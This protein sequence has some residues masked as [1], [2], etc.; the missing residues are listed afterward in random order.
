[1]YSRKKEHVS[2]KTEFECIGHRR[3][4][5]EVVLKYFSSKVIQNIYMD[6]SGFN[7]TG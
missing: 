5:S 2:F 4:D 6:F 1:M 3:F 7:P